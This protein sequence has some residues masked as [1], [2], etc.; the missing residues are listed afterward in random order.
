MRLYSS[1]N[2]EDSTEVH[3]AILYHSLTAMAE[4]HDVANRAL[5]KLEDQLTCGVCLDTLKD[6]KLLQCFHVY[7]KDCIQQLVVQDRRE[8]FSICC[9]I[10]R[11]STLLP[12]A[13]TDVSLLQSAFHI[14]PLLEIQNALEKL[15]EPKNMKCDTCNRDFPATSYCRDCGKFIC[16]MCASI[17][18]DSDEYVEHN[19]VAL[20]QS[21]RKEKQLDASK[22][23]TIAP[24]TKVRSL[25]FT[26]RHVE[27]SF[28]STVLSTIIAVQNTSMAL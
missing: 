12:S 20:E 26:V 24:F 22:K 13:T 18:S 7:C 6:P 8:Q 28:V 16:A 2:S 9:P 14:P 21:E 27:S 1:T 25:S 5:K 4:F 17:H 3:L 23:V 10:C 15:K 19:I 11:Q